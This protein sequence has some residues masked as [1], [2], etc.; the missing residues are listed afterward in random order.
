MPFGLT[1]ELTMNESIIR[2]LLII[3]KIHFVLS[4]AYIAQEFLN[5]YPYI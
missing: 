2:D 3:I 1:Y 4:F 5:I